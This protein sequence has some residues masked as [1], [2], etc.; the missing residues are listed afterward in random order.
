ML[1]PDRA[2]RLDLEARL[3]RW[4][5]DS[6]RGFVPPAGAPRVFTYPVDDAVTA[7]ERR[8]YLDEPVFHPELWATHRLLV[9]LFTEHL[10]APSPEEAD[11]AFVPLF[12]PV[13]EASERDLRPTMEALELLPTGLPHVVASLWDGYP[14]PPSRRANPFSMQSL[15]HLQDPAT[16]DE[17]WS[18]LDDRFRV[19]TLEASI[20]VD[21]AD[22]SVFPLVQPITAPPPGP[23]PLLYSFCG[24][25][26]YDHVPPD[27][28]RGA[29]NAPLWERLAQAGGD[30]FVGTLDDARRR[31]GQAAGYRTVP[32][33][34]TFTLCPA[35][36]SRWSYRVWEAVAAGSIPVILSD[37]MVRPF[38]DQLDWDA[39]A[40]H[41]PEAALPEIDD[42]VRSLHPARVAALAAGAEQARA[43][44]TPAGL[45]TLVA[46][47]L[48]P[49]GEGA[50]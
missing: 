35:G 4:I 41:V 22:V 45:A 15:G 32:A 18:W 50:A 44:M 38:G 42:I 25:L 31:F 11:V 29:A 46:Q 16:F 39:F 40:L 48:S 43:H 21:P 13:F 3:D 17:A 8:E 23:R 49:R 36:W 2:T 47:A 28:V 7:Y 12:L 1:G 5:A 10:A 30:S 27:H 9:R 24:A 20:D 34:S 19:L 26:A 33:T 37:Y 14:R 6:L